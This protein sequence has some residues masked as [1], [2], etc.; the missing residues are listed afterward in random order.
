MIRSIIIDDEIHC[1]KSL[2]SDLARYC[3]SVEIVDTCT[4]GKEGILSIKKH[5]PELVFLDVQMPWMT[6]FE[7]LEILEEVTFSIIFT[8]AHDE[9]AARAFRISAIDYLLKPIAAT[10]LQ[11]AVK[12]VA[13]KLKNGSDLQHINTLLQNF[14]K[15]SGQQKIALPQREGYEFVDLATIIYCYAE[16]AYTRIHI[17][18]KKPMLISRTLGDIEELLPSDI[19]QR[20]HHSTLVNLQYILQFL[21]TD[22]GCVVLKSGEK[23]AVSKSKKDSL[24][25]KLGLK[26][27]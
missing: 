9:Y 16:G 14:R 11:A 6:G 27:H 19:F 7:M 4:N 20:I 10:D 2:Q 5:Q 24:L 15:S 17:Q 3:P 23:L 21:R 26:K 1:I 13:E 18:D 25:E 12:K 8:T 22:G